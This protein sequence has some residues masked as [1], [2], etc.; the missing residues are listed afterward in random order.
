VARRRRVRVR[1]AMPGV[2]TYLSLIPVCRPPSH[3][4]RGQRRRCMCGQVAKL[5]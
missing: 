2:P 3:Q 5:A 1:V 4:W